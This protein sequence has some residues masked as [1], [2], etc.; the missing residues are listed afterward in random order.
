M[1]GSRPR[2]NVESLPAMR[3]GGGIRDDR[4][5]RT[6]AWVDPAGIR[7]LRQ[8]AAYGTGCPGVYA[9][10]GDHAPFDFKGGI[11]HGLHYT[12]AAAES[13]VCPKG[14]KLACRYDWNQREDVITNH[15]ASEVRAIGARGFRRDGYHGPGAPT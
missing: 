7:W 12:G 1:R 3:C 10:R 6:Y 8:N 13:L 4:D 5:A 15:Q 9:G 11:L 14:W 2:R